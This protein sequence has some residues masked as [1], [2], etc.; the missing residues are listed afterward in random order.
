MKYLIKKKRFCLPIISYEETYQNLGIDSKENLV[1]SLF[2]LTEQ[3][4]NGMK[5]LNKQS[6]DHIAP[7][8]R[9]INNKRNSTSITRVTPKSWRTLDL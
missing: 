2:V 5:C 7:Y 8:V 6:S 4:I 9:N 1:V 3:L